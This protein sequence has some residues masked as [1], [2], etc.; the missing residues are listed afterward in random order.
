MKSILTL[1]FSLSVCSAFAQDE[2]DIEEADSTIT[3]YLSEV[4]ISASK[5][6]QN[7]MEVPGK[8]STISKAFIALQ[9]PQTA[10]DMLDVSGNVFIQ[11]SQLGGGSPMIRGF[12]TNRVMLV[13]DGVRMN[14]A[15]FRSGNVQNVISF[16]ANAIEQSEIL[17]GP[18]SVIYGSDAIGGVMDFHTLTGRF[19]A[20]DKLTVSGNAFARYATANREKT[21]HGDINLSLN[22]WSFLTSLTHADY[23]DL[24]MGSH[25]PDEYTRPDYVARRDEMDVVVPN[26]EPNLQIHTGYRQLNAMQKISFR[27]GDQ[28]KVT[29]SF[30]YSTTSDYPRYDRL[31]L[32]QDGE[33]SNAEWYY[34][35][36][37]WMMNSLNFSFQQ[38][39]SLFD[40]SKFIIAYQDYQESRHSRGFNGS[41]RTDRSENVKALSFNLDL[42]KKL[43]NLF[44]LFYGAEYV[45]N[46]VY[47]QASRENILT[48][49]VSPTSTRYPDD[50]RWR[51]A[52]IY[53]SVKA[54]LS[55]KWIL[56]SSLRYSSVH[57]EAVFD[58]TFFDFPFERAA[59]SNNALN[60]ALGLV[61][62]PALKF[63]TFA[64]FSTGF[65]A[66]NIDDIG[67]V[68]ESVPGQVTVPNPDLKPEYAYNFEIGFAGSTDNKLQFDFAFY[69]TVIDNAISRGPSTF[70][71]EDSVDYD[72]TR[73]K[74]V[75]LQN[76]SSLWVSGIQAGVDIPFNDNLALRTVINYQ[77]GKERLPDSDQAYSP[78]HVAPLFGSTHLLFNRSR[79]T[80]DLYAKYNGEISY[81]DLALSE[82]ADNHLYAKD[83]NGNPYSPSWATANLK[84]SVR[85]R[86]IL[87]FDLGIENIFD[88]RYRPYSSGISAPGR[89]FIVAL[90]AKF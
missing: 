68:F 55:E 40:Q 66:P 79:L 88:K 33:F 49:E 9:N 51:S 73:S 82:R 75:S 39:F 57:S 19:T 85:P 59:I 38:S 72:G 5:W 15:I 47:S 22:K 3:T 13:L 2:P 56:S 64:N 36:Q 63:K 81:D 25:G 42:D 83:E 32:K 67:K 52:A 45:I 60:G 29:Y 7:V 35:P 24:R 28:F 71:G 50:S 27:T 37:K 23:D 12:A 62:K 21:L 11:K 78:T 1:C 44:T 26:D 89:N 61:F 77:Q 70:N 46:N 76:I 4:T 86:G 53:G 80:L 30:H 84:A 74:V 34:G 58:R 43:T 31:I 17:F 14:N 54:N 87:T 6:E 8:I 69:Y 65:R 48:G 10:A 18:G 20:T 16:D 90:R 41:R